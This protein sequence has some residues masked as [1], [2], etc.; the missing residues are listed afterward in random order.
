[1]LTG[2]SRDAATERCELD[3]AS[4]G[5]RDRQGRYGECVSFAAEAAEQAKT[6]DHPSGLAHALYLQH[7]MSVYLGRPEDRLAH[8]ALGIFEE[9]GDLVGQG[10]VL[11]NLG[12]SAYYRGQW[13]EALEF[14]ERSAAVRLRSGDVVGAATEENN[15]GEILSDQGEYE[16]ARSLFES[17]RSAWLAAGYKVGIAFATSNLGRLAARRGD[18]DGGQALLEQALAQFKEINSP[19]FVAETELRLVECDVLAGNFARADGAA[20]RLLDSIQGRAGFEQVEVS[21][22]RLLSTSR[23][24]GSGPRD[25]DQ[26]SAKWHEPRTPEAMLDDAIDRSAAMEATYELAVG[27]ATRAAFS[28]M[29]TGASRVGFDREWKSSAEDNLSAAEK[30]F[31][32]LGVKQAVIE[33]VQPMDRRTTIRLPGGLRR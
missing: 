30:I 11:N 23:L 6:A 33:L 28:G 2:L 32:R 26:G 18:V 22:L 14:Y 3:L 9:I 10:N 8:E 15:V 31:A 7:M 27:L 16:E 13:D 4:A 17:A 29:D 1:M 19:I 5:I 12:I 25:P 20:N 24:L 21:A